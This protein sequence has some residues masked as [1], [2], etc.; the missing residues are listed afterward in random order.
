MSADY[1]SCRSAIV[2]VLIIISLSTQALPAPASGMSDNR[3]LT[4]LL[5]EN[6]ETNKMWSETIA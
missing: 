2:W 1:V 6:S 4:W 5:A 3:L